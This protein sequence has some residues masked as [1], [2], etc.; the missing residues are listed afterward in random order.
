MKKFVVNVLEQRVTPFIVE[1]EDEWDA[2]M[3]AKDGEGYIEPTGSID[4]QIDPTTWEVLEYSSFNLW[5][6]W[7]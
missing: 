6:E 5:E 4:I 2:M 1:A 7:V 3:K